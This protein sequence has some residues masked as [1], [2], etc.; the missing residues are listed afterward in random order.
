MWF[1][2]ELSALRAPRSGSS[3]VHQP[4]TVATT[5]E[6]GPARGVGV[7]RG[8]ARDSAKGAPGSVL[9]VRA[10]HHPGP[11]FTPRSKRAITL[12]VVAA[13]ALTALDIGSKLAVEERLSAKPS[14]APPAVCAV[15][16]S[17]HI[18]GQQ[19]VPTAPYVLVENYL[20]LHYAENCGAAFG[21]MRTAPLAAR[22]GIF[23]VAALAAVVGLMWMFVQGRGQVFFAWSVPLIVSGALGNLF[24]RVRYGYV[25]DFIRFHWRGEWDYPTFNVAD[26]GIS[27]GV[28]LLILDGIL[29]GRAE[30]R[31]LEAAAGEGS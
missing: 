1:T 21:F 10:V 4:A 19:R 7:G 29:E 6:V 30:K 3:G 25:V 15:D 16:D 24:D 28:G 27:V 11:D 18:L 26:I 2:V 9:H 31:R 22:R 13:L 23:S 8:L 5:R 14:Y 12:C 17:G 20:E